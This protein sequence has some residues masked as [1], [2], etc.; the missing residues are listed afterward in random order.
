MKIKDMKFKSLLFGGFALALA[1]CSSE[2]IQT[3][4]NSGDNNVSTPESTLNTASVLVGQWGQTRVSNVDTWSLPSTRAVADW[5]KSLEFESEA[6]IIAKGAIDITSNTNNGNLYYIPSSFSGDIDLNWKN[7]YTGDKIYNFGEVNSFSNVNYGNNVDLYNAGIMINYAPSGNGMNIYNI[8][9]IVISGQ[10]NQ[11]T[12]YNNGDLTFQGKPIYDYNQPWPFPII[13]YEAPILPNSCSINSLGGTIE[14]PDGTNL[15]A[16]CDIHHT[17]YAEG[18]LT[19]ENS[20]SKY[21]CGLEVKGKFYLNDNNFSTSY[22]KAN[23]L[24]TQ[25]PMSLMPEALIEVTDKIINP[26]SGSTFTAVTGSHALI[27]T[28]DI[29]FKDNRDFDNCYSYNIYFEI[30]GSIIYASDGKTYSLDTY[31]SEKGDEKGRFNTSEISG[32][33]ACGPSYGNGGTPDVPKGPTLEEVATVDPPVSGEGHNHDID[34]TNGRHLSAT[35]I[36]WDQTTGT[37]YVSY[38]MRG[39]NYANDTYDNDEIEG[40]IE[41][42]QLAK[43]EMNQT[44]VQLGKYMWTTEFDFNHL[45]LDGSNIV[46]VGHKGG[47]KDSTENQTVN[48]GAII[49]RLPNTFDNFNPIDNGVVEGTSSQFEY[50]YLTTAEKLQSASGSLLDY[51]NAGDGNCVIKQGSEYWVATARGYGKVDSDFNRIKNDNGD[52]A[53]VNTPGSAKHIIKKGDN[54]VAVLYLNTRPTITAEASS[55]ASIA[56]V[57]NSTFPFYADVKEI[58]SFIQPVDG[59]NVLAWNGTNMFAC[60]GKGG[61][62]MDNTIYKFGEN[63]QEPVNGIDMDDQY[64]Y[65]AVGS[66]LRVLD[67]KDP[68]KPITSYHLPDMSANFVKVVDY[69][70]EKYIIVAYGQAG[71]KVFRL[72]NA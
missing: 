24:E 16:K 35:G 11:V 66:H 71:V 40:C 19:I 27:R 3:P 31:I 4:S 59:K 33:P 50:K 60:M 44:V 28:K 9:E 20:T 18:N 26:N 39:S 64:I 32:H 38:H 5:E 43:N 56:T 49:G 54:D 53:F 72:K 8:G 61:L 47:I 21:I 62:N 25:H 52:I 36:D 30:S 7:L 57:S 10:P 2:D 69:N 46:A 12:I 67:I 41:T 58:E 15:Q 17:V 65:L 1:A 45:I 68:N 13:G 22:L 23:I 55:T 42:W 6:E 48:Y 70:N 63:N 51:Q 29:E 14:F 34:K 37:I